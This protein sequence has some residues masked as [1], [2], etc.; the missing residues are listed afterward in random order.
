MLRCLAGLLFGSCLLA[1]AHGASAA[2]ERPGGR[3]PS[4]RAAAW[5][6]QFSPGMPEHPTDEDAGWAFVFPRY[7]GP[8]PCRDRHA[9]D[10]PSV[11]YLTTEAGV[12]PAG[13]AVTLEVEIVGAAEF[14]YRLE[15]GNT[16]DAPASVRLLIQRRGDDFTR[17]F[18]RWWSNPEAIVLAPGRHAITVPLAPD[19]WSNVLGK[20]GDAAPEEFRLALVD[21]GRVGM[22]FG[23]GCFFGHGV[24]VSGG[25]AIL[26]LTRFEVQ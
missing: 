24:S 9:D 26:R 12:L 5:D 21:A 17:E 6:I 7:D 18:Y 23:G 16:C 2:E 10:C 13:G 20:K 11:H 8:L 15:A 1:S 3:Q 22:T 25:P 4:M 19:Q 14:R